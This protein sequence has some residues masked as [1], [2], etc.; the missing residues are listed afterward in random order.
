[1][2]PPPTEYS[3]VRVYSPRSMRD[4]LAVGSAHVEADDVVEPGL[5]CNRARADHP[6]GR[7]RFHDVDRLHRG[8]RRRREAAV[9]LHDEQRGGDAAGIEPLAQ[10]LQIPFDDR[11]H[12]GVDH[13]GRGALVL[14]DLGKHVEAGATREAG[15]ELFDDFGHEA[16]V[17]RIGI[18]VDEADRDCVDSFIEQPP[19]RPPCVVA[20]ERA[21]DLARG[22][23]ALVDHHPQVALHERR[24]LLPGEIVEPRHPQVAKLQ[25]VAKALARDEP[26]PRAG[27]L[28]DRVRRHRGA[29]HD[30]GDLARRRPVL[31]EHRF[32]PL[33]DGERVVLDAR[34]DLH[35]DDVPAVVEQHDVGERA[36]DVDPDAIA[37]HGRWSRIT[38]G[39][40][41]SARAGPSW[42][43]P[44]EASTARRRCGDFIQWLHAARPYPLTARPSQVTNRRHTFPIPAI[45]TD[46]DA[47]FVLPSLT[48]TSQMDL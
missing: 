13:R 4:A 25:H 27:K 12:V 38:N 28:E 29:V 39:A 6:C 10:G 33:D 30:L 34:G 35:R 24:R 36:A 8:L 15:R 43:A 17:G 7:A 20:G 41:S 21:H 37:G 42:C 48:S 19:D 18:R 14:L 16:F 46:N 31:C 22:V 23:H 47:S 40:A 1:M 5:P 26:H 45:L 11:Q 32:Q 3:R 2:M 9:R 44:F